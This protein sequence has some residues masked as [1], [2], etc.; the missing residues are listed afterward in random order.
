M[1][2][3]HSLDSPEARDAVERLDG[4]RTLM[5]L[6]NFKPQFV[7]FILDG[8]KTHTIRAERKGHNDSAGET[9]HLYTG[10]RHKGARLLFRARCVKTEFVRI[11]TD[12]R[13]RIGAR[14]DL[15]NPDDIGGPAHS[16]GFIELDRSEKDLLAWRDGFRPFGSSATNP[17]RYPGEAFELMMQ[18]WEGRLPF[19]GVIYH[20][21]KPD[22]EK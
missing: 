22:G 14:N 1:D 21:R 13:V 9:M 4:I 19:E 2:R 20:W 11:E 8:T 3:N 5:G 12:W 7:P 17:S 18:F 15:D 16:G 10:L 6:Y